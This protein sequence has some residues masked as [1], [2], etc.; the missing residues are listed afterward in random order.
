[1][2]V[3]GVVALCLGA[4]LLAIAS[5]GHWTS[6]GD[7]AG[8]PP[9]Q[10]EL[11]DPH[12]TASIASY[13]DLLELT[14]S[15]LPISASEQEIMDVLYR[16]V[17]ARFTH[18][19][20]SHNIVSNWILASLGRLHS[21]FSHIWAPR[22][23]VAKGHSLLCDQ[24]SYLLLSLALENGVR[25]RHVGLNGHVVMEAW[26][27]SDWHLYDPDL[28]VVPYDATGRILSVEELALN[29]VLLANYYGR[30]GVVDIVGS[31]QD[32]TYV[33]F[34]LGARFEWKSQ[35]LADFEAVMEVAK[36]VIPLAM[37]LSGLLLARRPARHPRS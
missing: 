3:L 4:L 31:R 11:Y 30:H 7:Y 18:G 6:I 20:A 5:A 13:S 37:M 23:M 8:G 1:M 22:I 25:A 26:Y 27:D 29:P 34:P 2:R 33:G 10:G 15:R 24:S 16:T 14:R 28:E 9:R 21:T 35:L 36:F 32:N 12:L 17:A 19:E